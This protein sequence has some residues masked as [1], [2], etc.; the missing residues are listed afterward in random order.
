MADDIGRMLAP[1]D[2]ALLVSVTIGHKPC[3]TAH[4]TL[5]PPEPIRPRPIPDHSRFV[6]GNAP[7]AVPYADP[8]EH[9]SLIDRILDGDGRAYAELVTCYEHMVY[10]VCHRILRNT[11]DA[12]EAAQDSFVNAYQNLRSFGGNSKFSTWLYTIAYRSA[13]SRKRKRRQE[14]ISVDEL[15]HAP[16]TDEGKDLIHSSDVKRHLEKA[17]GTLSGED[18][19][20][21]TFYYLDELSVEEIVT[22]TGIGASNVKVKLY[23]CRKKLEEVLNAE[24]NGD[25]RSLLLEND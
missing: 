23:R 8:M 3:P 9:A 6:T 1:Y 10:T 14:M 5:P 16:S 20:V 13:I 22:I 17:L 7:F 11:E 19:A 12:Q 4:G 24:F 15:S 25:A 18:A 2:A 21:M